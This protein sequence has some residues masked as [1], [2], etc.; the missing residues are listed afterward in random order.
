MYSLDQMEKKGLNP[1]EILEIIII[2]CAKDRVRRAASVYIRGIKYFK[3]YTII[4]NL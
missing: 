1:F 3:K 4:L 2:M